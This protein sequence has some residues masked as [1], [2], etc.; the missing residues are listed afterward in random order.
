MIYFGPS[1][2][3][4][5]FY[6]TGHKSSLEMPEYVNSMGLNAYEYQC[7]R[8]VNVSEATARKLG[9][10]AV[11][12]GVKL[13]IHAPYY[14][15]PATD[16]EEKRLKTV[17]YIT[18]S[19]QA[20]MYMGADRIVVHTGGCA[21][22][23]RS[24]ALEN[25]KKTFSLALKTSEE[26]G[27]SGVYICPETMG[28]INQ[29]GTLEEVL[30]ICRLDERLMPT[31]D[32]GHLNARGLG[33][34]REFSDYEKIF[35]TL[36]NMLGC[37]RA[38]VFHAH[39]SRIEYTAGGEKKHHTLADTQYGPEFMPIAEIIYKRTYSPTIICESNGTMAH[40]AALLKGMYMSFEK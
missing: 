12:F 20:A 5:N 17:K 18:D 37:D 15:N 35:D 11:K 19:M 32:F 39:F 23:E 30:E 6:S 34:L 36:E 21:K 25:A 16:D 13:S 9:E 4:E 22:M 10:N 7:S 38:K 29:L 1:G 14:V 26:L 40:D 28:K 2:N 27:L 24:V 31:I 3:E 33:C 8:G